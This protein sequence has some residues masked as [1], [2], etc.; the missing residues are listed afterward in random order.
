MKP[1]IVS[2]NS[3]LIAVGQKTQV[4]QHYPILS[5]GE[6][7]NILTY[8]K[9][10]QDLFKAIGKQGLSFFNTSGI[11][12]ASES[13]IIEET[14]WQGK[15]YYCLVHTALTEPLFLSIDDK[16]VSVTLEFQV[17]H[18]KGRL[19]L[20]RHLYG[21]IQEQNN[22][23][24]LHNLGADEVV[25]DVVSGRLNHN[26]IRE[27]HQKIPVNFVSE[28]ILDPKGIMIHIFEQAINELEFV[29]KPRS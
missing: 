1:K 26:V 19:L 4:D 20:L 18:S 27:F 15:P 14:Q 22:P 21:N 16:T 5:K 9:K 2:N 10:V 11:I 8:D 23:S 29:N 7:K 13:S 24:S 25:V 12:R 3:T 28:K 6:L 17:R